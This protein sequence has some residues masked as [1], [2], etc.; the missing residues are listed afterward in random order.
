M[1]G[2][3]LHQA[4]PYKVGDPL[5]PGWRWVRLGEI[6][7]GVVE[8]CNP[9]DRFADT[10]RYIDISSV[11][12][13]LKRIVT[14]QIMPAEQAP[15]RARQIVKAYDVLVATTR[16]NLNAVALVPPEL[17]GQICSTGFCVLRA[18]DEETARL[19]FAFVQSPPFISAVSRLVQGALYPAITDDDVRNCQMAFPPPK[20]RKAVTFRLESLMA[21][22]Q[23][24]RA[25]AERQLE[26][27]RALPGALLNEVFG[28]FESPTE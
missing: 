27:V 18:P 16:P 5:P 9:A 14:P 8:T 3:I 15:S 7:P 28:G 4:F 1:Q 26:A 6:A 22:V 20:E 25:A 12:N 19:I 23:R 11:D 2:A 17:D 10:F 24:L 21:E 13:V